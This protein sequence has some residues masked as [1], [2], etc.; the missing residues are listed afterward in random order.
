MPE[1]QQDP[2]QSREEFA[3]AR[4]ALVDR[5]VKDHPGLS[6]T[7]F[8]DVKI[9]DFDTHATTLATQ[10]VAADREAGARALGMTVEEF[11]ALKKPAEAE[12]TPQSRS[13]SLPSGKATQPPP[14]AQGERV[15]GLT[16]IDLIE[17]AAAEDYAH[18]FK[19]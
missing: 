4:R 16:G 14:V 11:D 9:A 8:N 6:H 5:I 12:S 18:L 17:Q 15:G 13:A 19:R 7:D 3:E 2:K 1:D 10:R